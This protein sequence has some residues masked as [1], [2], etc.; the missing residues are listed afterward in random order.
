[1]SVVRSDQALNASQIHPNS[2][3]PMHVAGSYYDPMSN[4]SYLHMTVDNT[5]RDCFGD[6]Q[7]LA[8]DEYHNDALSQL[9]QEWFLGLGEDV[10]MGR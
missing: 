9:S 4:P 7:D 1:M 2:S 10:L 8:L 5:F 3:D 6:L